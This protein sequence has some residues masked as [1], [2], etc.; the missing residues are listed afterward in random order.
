MSTSDMYSLWKWS[1]IWSSIHNILLFII[2]GFTLQC[3]FWPFWHFSSYWLGVKVL[4]VS[5]WRH[6]FTAVGCWP[7]HDVEPCFIVRFLGAM[8]CGAWTGD[9]PNFVGN[10]FC[11]LDIWFVDDRCSDIA[12]ACCIF[13]IPICLPHKYKLALRDGRHKETKG[14][15][16]K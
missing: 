11:L 3:L 2:S 9:A 10:W 5:A 12:F 16:W 6:I 1:I 13:K 14:H 8:L 4:C 7:L 15:L